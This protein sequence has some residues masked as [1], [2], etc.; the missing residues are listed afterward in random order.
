MAQSVT[1]KS[2]ER[3]GGLVMHTKMLK[4]E[5]VVSV[6]Q[7]PMILENLLFRNMPFCLLTNRT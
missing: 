3:E 1:G 6:S 7:V 5:R 2:V 4:Y